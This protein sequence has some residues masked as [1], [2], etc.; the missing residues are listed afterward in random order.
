MGPRNKKKIHLRN[1]IEESKRYFATDQYQTVLSLA[2]SFLSQ[3]N[4]VSCSN[5]LDR[6]PTKDQLLESLV[7]K[8]KGK[9]V[10]KT[11]RQI[12][13][14]DGVSPLIKIKGISSL[15]THCIIE[16][17]SGRKEYGILLPILLEKQSELIYG[18]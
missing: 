5:M 11:L 17:E 8:L 12:H 4:L 9:S 14:K 10:Y 13:E 3:G 16:M 18:L 2:E 1:R 7:A 15:L 6:L